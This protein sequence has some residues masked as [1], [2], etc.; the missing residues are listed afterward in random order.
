MFRTAYQ[1]NLFWICTW[2]QMA[3]YYLFTGKYQS[4]N[5]SVCTFNLQWSEKQS[6]FEHFRRSSSS[7]QRHLKVYNAFV[8]AVLNVINFLIILAVFN[9]LGGNPICNKANIPNIGLFCGSE[10]GPD[11]TSKDSTN[12]NNAS[13]PIAACPTDNFFDYVPESPISCFCASP[14]RI[15]YRLKSPS[16]SFFPPY[17]YIFEKYL[18]S[19]LGLDLYQLRIDSSSWE[20]GPHRLKMDLKLYP[21][22]NDNHVNT[23]NGSEV[24]RIRGRFTSWNFPR[25]DFFGPYELLN[26]TLLGPYAASV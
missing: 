26:F 13:C 8:F 21:K 4:S 1:S 7:K 14:L 3:C 22:A 19:T 18:T 6:A 17:K 20:E 12:S 11:V 15:G 23:F 5:Q 24:E 9:R 16:F 25:D 2:N 10:A